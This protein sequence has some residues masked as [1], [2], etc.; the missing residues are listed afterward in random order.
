MTAMNDHLDSAVLDELRAVLGDEFP[1]LVNTFLIDSEK[2]VA[3][4]RAAS[5]AANATAL[6]EAAHSF[7]G[8]ALNMGALRLSGLCVEA[9]VRART[10]DVTGI[11][12]LVDDIDAEMRLVNGLLA[13]ARKA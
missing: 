6:R 1:A 8:S 4:L 13:A 2:R 10:G 12:G 5:S 3:A 9:E 11:E 7:K